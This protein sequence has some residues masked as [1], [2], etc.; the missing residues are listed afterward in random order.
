[1]IP[2]VVQPSQLCASPLPTLT[3]S[4]STECPLQHVGEGGPADDAFP[5]ILYIRECSEIVR[6]S[7]SLIYFKNF[8]FSLG[9]S[10]SSPSSSSSSSSSCLRPPAAWLGLPETTSWRPSDASTPRRSRC[11]D[12]P[13][14]C[15]YVRTQGGW[16]SLSSVSVHWVGRT[17][18]VSR[19]L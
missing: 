10:S 5:T 6:L 11:S 9:H 2:P 12:W 19:Q 17:F 14:F 4:T 15:R 1:M 16:H 13:K 18:S 7:E 3:R 8:R